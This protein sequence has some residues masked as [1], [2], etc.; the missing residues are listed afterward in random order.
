MGATLTKIYIEIAKHLFDGC[1][2]LTSISIPDSVTRI[3]ASAFKSCVSLSSVTIPN[4]VTSIEDFTFVDAQLEIVGLVIKSVKIKLLILVAVGHL[5]MIMLLMTK[6]VVKINLTKVALKIW[7]LECIVNL[8][9]SNLY[10]MTK[11]LFPL[12]LDFT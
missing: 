7:S 11:L 6:L 4:G 5:V 9:V 1:S 12:M 3:E 10:E 2:S 8:N